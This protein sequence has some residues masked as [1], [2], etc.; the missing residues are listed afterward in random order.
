MISFFSLMPVGCVLVGCRQVCGI[1][2]QLADSLCAC[3]QRYA[4]KI[5]TGSGLY[6]QHLHCAMAGVFVCAAGDIF[7]AEETISGDRSRLYRN[8]FMLMCG[9]LLVGAAV[10]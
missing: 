6:R 9:S 3:R 10:A 5:S 4:G 2:H 8:R 7:P 1:H